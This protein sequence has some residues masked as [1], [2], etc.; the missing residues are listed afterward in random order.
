VAVHHVDV[1]RRAAG[2]GRLDLVV[3]VAP[4]GRQRVDR[5][6]VKISASAALMIDWM[7]QAS[8]DAGGGVGAR[9]LAGAEEAPERDLLGAGAGDGHGAERGSDQ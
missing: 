6:A 8:P 7:M 5:D 1:R 3:V 4:V 9:I 2:I